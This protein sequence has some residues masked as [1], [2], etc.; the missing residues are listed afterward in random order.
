M[1]TKFASSSS[2]SPRSTNAL[3]FS[4]KISGQRVIPDACSNR[5]FSV[6][7]NQRC[8]ETRENGETVL[9]RVFLP[10]IQSLLQVCLDGIEARGS[11]TVDGAM[12]EDRQG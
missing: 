3:K 8:S 2:I 10:V 9:W 4:M 1:L 7:T 11:A 12:I 6:T 5:P